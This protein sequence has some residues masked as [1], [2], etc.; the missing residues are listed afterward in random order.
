MAV[1]VSELTHS[2]TNV[3][4]GGFPSVADRRRPKFMPPSDMSFQQPLPPLDSP[5]MAT[6]QSGYPSSY[7]ISTQQGPSSLGGD[8]NWTLQRSFSNP[9][10]A[11]PGHH[12]AEPLQ[13]GVAGEKK[14]NK[15]GYH[16][17]SVACSE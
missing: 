5:E 15:L 1:G 2:I 10:V 11:G 17:T 3:G 14:R 8:P 12:N 6:N 7:D 4:G 16:R 13:S 9:D